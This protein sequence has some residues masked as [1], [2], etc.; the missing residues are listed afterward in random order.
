LVIA[1]TGPKG[2]PK[3]ELVGPG[4]RQELGI[5]VGAWN[6]DRPAGK[7]ARLVALYPGNEVT[8]LDLDQKKLIPL[9]SGDRVAAIW[10]TRALVR[11]KRGLVLYDVVSGE[12]RA[13]SGTTLPL[14][15]SIT[16]NQYAA[17]APLVV[18]LSQA[19]V[20]GRID[21]RPLAIAPDGRVAIA[22][23]GSADGTR[24]A[25]GPMVW[26]SPTPI[27]EAAH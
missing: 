13:L 6:D 5:D 2:R 14:A 22:D 8:L 25:M 1:C 3:L 10:Q 21:G 7:S 27:D 12:R 18:D 16:N 23:G 26:H 11:R 20:L 4:F 19:R 24:L 17:V 15:E 9:E